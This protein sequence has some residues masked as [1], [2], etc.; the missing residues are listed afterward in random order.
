MTSLKLPG[1]DERTTTDGCWLRPLLAC[2]LT[3]RPINRWIELSFQN[4]SYMYMY[5]ENPQLKTYQLSD[6]NVPYKHSQKV[7]E[8]L[9]LHAALSA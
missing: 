4:S 7:L 9:V 1:I 8:A 6:S 2:P 5:P 3:L